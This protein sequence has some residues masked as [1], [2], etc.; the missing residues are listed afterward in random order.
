MRESRGDDKLLEEVNTLRIDLSAALSREEGLRNSL[1]STMG[2]SSAKI[3]ELSELLRASEERSGQFE[4]EMLRKAA[5]EVEDLK[6]EMQHREHAHE[7]ALAELRT[8]LDE[9]LAW[10]RDEIEKGRIAAA[11][12][13][14]RAREEADSCYRR[15]LRELATE[16]EDAK[17]RA[18]GGAREIADAER[19]AKLAEDR[20]EEAISRHWLLESQLEGSSQGSPILCDDVEGEESLGIMQEE[21]ICAEER[22]EKL[23]RRVEEERER[24]EGA[25]RR[26]TEERERVE[27]LERRVE[28]EKERADRAEAKIDEERRL[29][30]EKAEKVDR[31]EP[32]RNGSEDRYMQV[33]VVEKDS[34]GGSA[35]ADVAVSAVRWEL[36]ETLER[37][38][39]AEVRAEEAHRK[40][41][42]A[43]RR[44]EEAHT[45]LE[46]ARKS[47]EEAHHMVEEAQEEL[48]AFRV[49]SRMHS[50]RVMMRMSSETRQKVRLASATAAGQA[51]AMW[52]MAAACASRRARRSAKARADVHFRRVLALKSAL[53]WRSSCGGGDD[54]SEIGHLDDL[55]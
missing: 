40:A 53:L 2:A 5:D 35:A 26:V 41:E 17:R 54:G 48:G 29:V 28:E 7:R 22:V 10:G 55:Y 16:L 39:E 51:K 15:S 42:E 6:S 34:H 11:D 18:G 1:S 25:E 49:E 14:V 23:E 12:A 45:D 13:V 37:A 4:A 20:A 31:T 50:E 52:M 3:A 27:K 44:A 46:E 38:K 47:A 33:G 36:E 9:A 19:R 32:W 8:Q 24:A 30:V 43:Q 21:L